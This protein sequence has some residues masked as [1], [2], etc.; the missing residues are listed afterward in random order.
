[1][2]LLDFNSAYKK[3]PKD[4]SGSMTKNRFKNEIYWGI[5]KLFQIHLNNIDYYL[6]FDNA[7]DI[8]VFDKGTSEIS[9]YQIKTQ[10]NNF[11]I[12]SITKLDK[13]NSILSTL[14]STNSDYTSEMCL[15]AKANLKVKN[16]NLV[17]KNFFSFDELYCEEKDIIRSHLE[18]T[19]GV[20]TAELNKITFL[21][22]EFLL[23]ESDD[24]LLGHTTRFL[25]S[26]YKDTVIKPTPFLDYLKSQVTKKSSCEIELNDIEK[27]VEHKGITRSEIEDMIEKFRVAD[28][29]IVER[30]KSKVV[31]YIPSYKKQISITSEI[32]N[33][34]RNSFDKELINTTIDNIIQDIASFD[35]NLTEGEV[36]EMLSSKSYSLIRNCYE[37]N[38]ALVLLAMSK[39]EEEV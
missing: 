6:I 15:V 2:I 32:T 26:V 3:I 1:M 19:L 31:K 36:F 23:S 35:E 4:T 17:K 24:L 29:R 11:T 14:Y 22:A 33:I 8:E 28:T 38:C 39:Y 27:A 10:A 5:I 12:D 34:N 7:C 16:G 37:E 13:T 18:S 21:K 25:E 9:F 30:A 20:K